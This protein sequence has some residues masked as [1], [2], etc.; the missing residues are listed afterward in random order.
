MS[1]F[2]RLAAALVAPS[3]PAGPPPPAAALPRSSE[4]RARSGFWR[5]PGRYLV[6]SAALFALLVYHSGGSPWRGDFWIYSATVEALKANPSHPGNPL[7]GTDDA[8][9][10]LSPYTWGVGLLARALRLPPVD[11]LVVQGLVNLVLFLAALYAFVATW[12][13]RRAAAFY[14]LL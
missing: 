13:E 14:A 3:R 6:L 7:F 12:L 1:F 9:A 5:G 4:A 11:A 8:F 10:F 2:E